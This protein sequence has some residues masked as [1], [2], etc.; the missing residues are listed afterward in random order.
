M[1]HQ[2]EVVERRQPRLVSETPGTRIGITFRHVE[3]IGRGKFIVRAEQ[4]HDIAIR[5]GANLRPIFGRRTAGAFRL[6]NQ[7]R[8]ENV[9]AGL[10]REIHQ[11]IAGA[12]WKTGANGQSA[13]LVACVSVGIQYFRRPADR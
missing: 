13:V 2:L 12:A 1:D 11:Q 8:T 5:Q 10:D 7:D 9:F 4:Q 6:W 3:I